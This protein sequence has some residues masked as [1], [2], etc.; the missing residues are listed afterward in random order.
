MW[1][2]NKTTFSIE[3]VDSAVAAKNLGPNTLVLNMASQLY[4]GGGFL[5]GSSAQE[6]SLFRCSL[7]A[8]VMHLSVG[9]KKRTGPSHDKKNARYANGRNVG[10]VDKAEAIELRHNKGNPEKMRKT[11]GMALFLLKIVSWYGGSGATPMELH[12]TPLALRTSSTCWQ[13]LSRL[14]NQGR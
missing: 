7:N 10:Y 5:H 9:P 14:S 4:P 6:E 2:D 11:N 1:G 8:G 3:N 12:T 13:K